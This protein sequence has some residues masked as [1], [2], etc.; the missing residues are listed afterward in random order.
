M[1]RDTIV[2]CQTV[3]VATMRGASLGCAR[4]AAMRGDAYAVTA[5]I[6]TPADHPIR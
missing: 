3:R 5:S 2:L 1:W 4:T 6:G